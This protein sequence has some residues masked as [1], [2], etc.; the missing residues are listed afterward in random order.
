MPTDPK[1]VARQIDAA[2]SI[3]SL[4]A[5][6]EARRVERALAATC[7]AMAD[8]MARTQPASG[9]GS[10][11][12]AGGFAIYAGRGSPLTQGMAMGLA[13]PVGA[14]ELDVFETFVCRDGQRSRQL[15]LCPFADPSLPAILAAR[16]YRVHEWQLAWVRPMA[17]EIFA[18]PPP[19]ITVRPV[20]SGE[21]ELF[22]R[23]V[24]AGFLETEDV[25]ADAIAMLLPTTAAERQE[26]YFAMLG[27]EPI[28]GATLAWSGGV[29]FV[30]GSAV[31][32]GYRGR[33]AQGALIRTRLGRALEL[34]CD[35]AASVTLPGTSSRRN[36]ERHGFHVA[37]PKVLMLADA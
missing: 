7:R 34:G 8:S 17:D 24:M 18:P 25:P 2:Q 28:G 22:C 16:G 21:E 30:N 35:L 6:E 26:K 3:L 19:G 23:V 10:T 29:A 11:E 32:P 31:R 12:V 20:T 36:M 9:A 15:E 37:Y 13:G 14:A 27:G 33:G 1:D 4:P 5:A